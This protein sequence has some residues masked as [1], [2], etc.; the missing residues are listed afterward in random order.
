MVLT[1][2]QTNPRRLTSENL[3]QLLPEEK[4]LSAHV[5]R[6]P[7]QACQYGMRL[8]EEA[9]ATLVICDSFFLAAETRDWVITQS[10]TN[11]LD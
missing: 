1:E 7:L 9:E 8:A 2:F 10:A 5:V 6:P 4:K 3:L 11:D